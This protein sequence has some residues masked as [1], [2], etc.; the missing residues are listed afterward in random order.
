MAVVLTQMPRGTANEIAKCGSG[1][2]AVSEEERCTG[3]AYV[4]ICR[5]D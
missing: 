1:G 4:V 2:A 3:F 5:H